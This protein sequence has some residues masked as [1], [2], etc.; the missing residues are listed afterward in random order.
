MKENFEVCGCSKNSYAIRRFAVAS[1]RATRM[2]A[3]RAGVVY[4]QV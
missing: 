2:S 3:E 1:N 4:R